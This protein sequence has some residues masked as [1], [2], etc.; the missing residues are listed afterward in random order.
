MTLRSL[1][2]LCAIALACPA[3]A[4]TSSATSTPQV[5]TATSSA[6]TPT[7][8]T[9]SFSSGVAQIGPMSMSR[10][11]A[12]RVK[13]SGTW[14]GSAYIGTTTDGCVTVSP[15]T[16]GASPVTYTANINEIVD[17]PAT[18]G[19]E[20]YCLVATVTSGTLAYALRQ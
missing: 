7:S 14:T 16:V 8:G 9:A 11:F 12:I 1:A 19:A 5:G 13:L 2:L 17:A 15:L 4:Q 20:P 3:H 10:G 18:T 6:V